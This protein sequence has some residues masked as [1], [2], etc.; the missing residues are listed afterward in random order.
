V[1]VVAIDEDSLPGVASTEFVTVAL[2][3]PGLKLGAVAEI[4]IVALP[5]AGRLPWEH[6]TTL[7]LTAQLK[8]FDAL[9]L[10]YVTFEGSVS[11]TTTLLTGAGW[12]C[13]EHEILGGV[14]SSTSQVLVGTWGSLRVM[15]YEKLPP[16]ATGLGDAATLRVIVVPG[17]A[18]K[19]G[20]TAARGKSSTPAA[21]RAWASRRAAL[22]GDGTLD[23]MKVS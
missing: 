8:P 17:T 15:V 21:V 16:E 7:P 10:V 4:V 12:S 9:E 14:E 6:V 3:P 18:A 19:A 11:V 20:G 23:H 1:T 2:L 5:Y 13:S 22:G